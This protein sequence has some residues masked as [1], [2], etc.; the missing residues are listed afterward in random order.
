MFK[1]EAK[2][3]PD[4]LTGNTLQR[5]F[6]NMSYRTPLTVEADYRKA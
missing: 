3:S 6:L 1:P 5:V 2:L 4:A